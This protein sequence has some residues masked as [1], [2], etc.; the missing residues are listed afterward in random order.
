M[1]IM[2]PGYFPDTLF[3]DRYLHDE[4]WLKSGDSGVITTPISPGYFPSNIFL[5]GYWHDN[6]WLNSGAVSNLFREEINLESF[7][8]IAE[9]KDSNIIKGINSDSGIKTTISKFSETDSDISISRYSPINL[10]VI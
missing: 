10:E 8:N 5:A 1:G 7:I 9:N 6:Y 3:L 2:S 4:Y